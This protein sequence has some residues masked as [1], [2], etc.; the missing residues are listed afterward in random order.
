MSKGKTKIALLDQPTAGE[1]EWSET[2]RAERTADGSF[3]SIEMPELNP[4]IAP[5]ESSIEAE[6]LFFSYK[7]DLQKSLSKLIFSGGERFEVSYC[8][9]FCEIFGDG[10]EV[11]LEVACAGQPTRV[12][13]KVI[14]MFRASKPFYHVGTQSPYKAVKTN[15]N[16]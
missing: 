9:L 6:L 4:V 11:L 13:A 7:Q 3:E 8:N 2:Q 16:R 10:R 12:L 14:E 15:L 1:S 5:D